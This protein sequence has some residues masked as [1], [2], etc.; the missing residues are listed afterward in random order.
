MYYETKELP[1]IAAKDWGIKY[2]P[3]IHQQI[4][5]VHVIRGI[6]KMNIGNQA[7][8]LFPGDFAF[9]FPTILHDY[10]MVS[11]RE[12]IW[13]QI[14]N[15]QTDLL[16]WHQKE[17]LQTYPSKPVIRSLQMHTDALFAESRLYELHY[18][19]QNA[20]LISSL[21]SLILCRAFDK[22][23]LLPLGNSNT[24][25]ISEEVVSYIS[26]HF[27]ED[28]TLEAVANRF[29]IGKYVL[30]RIFSKTL[31]ISFL[32]YIN[33]LRI[34]HAEY[35]LLTTNMTVMEIA[36]E[37]GYHNQQTFNRIFKAEYE[38]TPT[39]Y[40]SSHFRDL[41]SPQRDVVIRS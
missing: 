26:N 38:C 39:E 37:C 6:I 9:I 30:S 16:P 1:F 25:D 15:C 31:H 13:L 2:P 12:D 18:E 24:Q 35:L 33:S 10:D 7:Y 14:L 17:L 40:R 36:I 23:Q 34:S 27:R 4:E 20:P 32:S 19:E 3:H 28:L 22:L 41:R 8:Q 5:I 29:G 11:N 21:V